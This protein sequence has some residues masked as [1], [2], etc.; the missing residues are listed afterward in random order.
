MES[1]RRTDQFLPSRMCSLSGGDFKEKGGVKKRENVRQGV[2]K[3]GRRI[4]FTYRGTIVELDRLG[5]SFSHV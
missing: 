5:S 4:Q 2:S 3:F 1:I